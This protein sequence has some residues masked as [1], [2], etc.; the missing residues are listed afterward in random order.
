MVIP[1]FCDQK[2][3]HAEVEGGE[4]RTGAKQ[5]GGEGLSGKENDQGR[6]ATPSS[7]LLTLTGTL[8]TLPTGPAGCG[9]LMCLS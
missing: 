8:C 7:N 3:L 9:I 2:T 6:V 1:S 5:R 4:E